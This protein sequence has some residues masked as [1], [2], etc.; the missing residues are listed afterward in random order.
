MI[1]PGSNVSV[2]AWLRSVETWNVS[3]WF[4]SNEG[5]LTSARTS[6]VCT[7]ITT[8]VALLA[9]CATRASCSSLYTRYCRRVS[10]DRRR[11]RPSTGKVT[12][13]TSSMTRPR[14]S[15]MTRREP[16][17]P[18]N[19]WLNVSST[20]SCPWSSTLLKPT[21]WAVTSPSG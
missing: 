21:M 4:G 5:R 11:S 2:I 1:E 14:R 15:L 18:D 6:P 8:A 3:R 10:M 16:G 19:C 12:A 17:W 9:W 20:P 7:S 13:C